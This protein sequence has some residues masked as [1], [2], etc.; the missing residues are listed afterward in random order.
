MFKC[1]NLN[2]YI[3][4]KYSDIHNYNTKNNNNFTAPNYNMKKSEMSINIKNIRGPNTWI[5]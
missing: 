2:S 5:L 1:L 3:L 4:P